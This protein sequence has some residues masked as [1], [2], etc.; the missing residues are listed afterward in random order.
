MSKVHQ[1][2]YLCNSN[3][4]YEEDMVRPGDFWSLVL[5]SLQE[6]KA[7]FWEQAGAVG[8]GVWPALCP[9]L[10]RGPVGLMAAVALQH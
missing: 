6:G 1:Y 3:P 10:H 7:L 8:T 9:A 2:S 4:R 5:Q